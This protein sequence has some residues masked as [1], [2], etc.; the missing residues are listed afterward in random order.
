[1]Q[2][3]RDLQSHVKKSAEFEGSFV[4]NLC[5]FF[6]RN[7]FFLLKP[8]QQVCCSHN[9]KSMTNITLS[10]RSYSVMQ[11]LEKHMCLRFFAEHG[12]K[13]V[14]CRR[15]SFLAGLKLEE[16]STLFAPAGFVFLLE[17]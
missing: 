6:P 16:F 2:A 15:R 5:G 1:M 8:F 14:L 17:F 7:G 11:D 13:L 4:P 9:T 12:R 3:I 10:W